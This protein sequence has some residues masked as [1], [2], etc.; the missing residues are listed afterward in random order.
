MQSFEANFAK[1]HEHFSIVTGLRGLFVRISDQQIRQEL[2]L[3]LYAN[4]GESFSLETLVPVN[5][6]YQL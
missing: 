2:G 4:N 1:M 3:S 6:F 5:S